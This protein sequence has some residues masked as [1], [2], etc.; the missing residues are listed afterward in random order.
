MRGPQGE[1]GIVGAYLGSSAVITIPAGGDG[2]TFASCDS[3]D[4]VAGGGF[5]SST[6]ERSL[7]I[8]EARPADPDDSS[9]P[10]TY[11]VRATNNTSVAH[12]LQVW[13]ACLDI[14]P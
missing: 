6:G 2:G 4:T 1:P 11:S 3:G 14:T 9:V 5:S 8:F 12:D 7:D 13:V 10:S